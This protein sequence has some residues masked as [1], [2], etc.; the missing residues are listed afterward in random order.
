MLTQPTVEPDDIIQQM[1]AIRNASE[2]HVADLHDEAQ[3]LVDWREYVRAQPVASVA[4]VAAIGFVVMNRMSSS[5]RCPVVPTSAIESPAVQQATANRS[6][7]DGVQ[8]AIATTVGSGMMAFLG[9]LASAAVK[10][11]ALRKLGDFSNDRY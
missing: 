8:P 2:A 3:R 7:T 6:A 1:N 5:N 9:S 11:Y 4:T 10:Q